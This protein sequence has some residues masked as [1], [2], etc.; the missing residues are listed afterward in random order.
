MAECLLAFRRGDDSA[1][2][3]A[4]ALAEADLIHEVRQIRRLF[5]AVIKG[6]SR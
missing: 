5:E 3:D 4:G 1:E 6:F 2:A